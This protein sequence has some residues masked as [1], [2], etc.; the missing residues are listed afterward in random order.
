MAVNMPR[1][2]TIREVAP[3][4]GLQI[5]KQFVPTDRKI[6]L[7]DHLSETGVHGIQYTSFVP[8]K[9]V[10]QFADAEEVARRIRRRAGVQYIALIPNEKGLERAVAAGVDEV[11]LP[12]AATESFAK[13]NLNRSIDECIQTVAN[14]VAAAPQ[15]LVISASVSM[16]FGCPYE[17]LVPVEQVITI[18]ERI[19]ETGAPVITLGD[20]T[21]MG[22]PNLVREVVA[23]LRERCPEVTIATHFHDTRG[24]GLANAVAALEEG[25]T[26][27]DGSVG[28]LG[29]C[30]YAPDAT[31]NISTEDLVNMLHGMGVETGVNLAALVGCAKL[32]E[33]IMDRTLPGLVMKAGAWPPPKAESATG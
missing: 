15:G 20:T 3:R 18:C 8:P 5:E 25:V 30:P 21:G 14:V 32:A 26:I 4:D 6:E 22:N 2:V 33:E 10:P 13:R 23:R 27:F 19:A 7:I 12:S 17:G 16:C 24:A 11:T 31:G 1:K 9:W 29:G 28:G